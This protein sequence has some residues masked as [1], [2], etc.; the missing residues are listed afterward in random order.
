MT[1]M[2]RTPGR[3]RRRVLLAAC[4]A[5]VA[6]VALAG[7]SSSDDASMS[8][9]GDGAPVAAPE[10]GGAADGGTGADTDTAAAGDAAQRQVVQTGKVNLQ[11]KDALVATEK[12][13]TL[14]EQS[15]GRVDDRAEQASTSDRSASADLT[16]RVPATKVSSTIDAL[17]GLGTVQSVDLSATDVT[18][19]AQDLDARIDALRMSIARME[20][21]LAGAT[22][23]KDL[24]AAEDALTERQGDLEKLVSERA[25]LADQVSLSTISV[26]V[27]G[28]DVSPVADPGPRSF[29]D[30]LAVGWDA[31]VSMV[32]GLMV[33]TGVLLPWLL[34]GGAVVALAVA[35]QRAYRRRRPRKPAPQHP[36]YYP[37]LAPAGA[38]A[39]GPTGGR[40]PATNPGAATAPT[41]APT[42]APTDGPTS[43]PGDGTPPQPN[44]NE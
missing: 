24:I 44:V 33:V 42:S 39:G 27:Y 40:P 30:G 37:H 20:K 32:K 25:R 12:I 34:F 38:T 1:T 9:A 22:S 13:V 31:F 16:L 5:L 23:N 18:G 35:A 8:S 14:V 6:A 2:R 7:C 41:S 4:A 15:G 21:L 3:T 26:H 36:V 28:P 29:L 17:R 19:A 11:T 43:A 10:A